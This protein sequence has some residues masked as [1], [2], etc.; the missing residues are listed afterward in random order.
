A[1][2]HAVQEVEVIVVTDELE[3]AEVGRN[4]GRRDHEHALFARTD[5]H[6]R[7]LLDDP[8]LNDP[9][10]LDQADPEHFGTGGSHGA[11]HRR[12]LTGTCTVGP[13]RMR[14]CH[15]ESLDP[16][17]AASHR[18]R[19]HRPHPKS[20]TLHA[21]EVPTSRPSSV[22]KKALRSQP[23]SNDFSTLLPALPPRAELRSLVHHRGFPGPG[24]ARSVVT[25]I[26]Q[27]A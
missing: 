13:M 2:V 15:S 27:S 8:L 25:I 11:H 18:K 1:P 20:D 16:L 9:P 24:G 14:L 22:T 12:H 10:A 17:R 7:S 19:T 23:N 6:V 21:E 26:A 4:A 3:Q 5:G